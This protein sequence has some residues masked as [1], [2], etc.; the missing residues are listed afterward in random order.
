MIAIR[1]I[2]IMHLRLAVTGVVLPA[3]L[4]LSLTLLAAIHPRLQ[5]ILITI[6]GI[7]L[8]VVAMLLLPR[9]KGGST[10]PAWKPSLA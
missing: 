9:F 3:V 10:G 5:G 2:T 7:A 1:A 6:A 8:F 4:I